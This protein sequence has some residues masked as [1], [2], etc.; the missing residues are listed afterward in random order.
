MTELKKLDIYL[1]IEGENYR[2]GQLVEDKNYFFKYDEDFLN[3]GLDISPFH[4]PLNK[5]IY[6]FDST[7]LE[8]LP[9][10]FY[11]S[12]PDGWGRLLIDR[13]LVSKK[14]D[15]T[16]ISAL[17]RLSLSN[18]NSWGAFSY[19]PNSNIEHL[20]FNDLNLSKIY[21]EAIKIYDDEEDSLNETIFELGSSSGGARPK[22]YVDY[23]I[24]NDKIFNQSNEHTQPWIIK[25]ATSAE[26]KD[27][28][29][30]EMIYSRVAVTAG[31][32]MMPCKLFE[33]KKGRFHFGTQRF[34]R[35]DKGRIH[36]ISAAGLL[37]DNFRLSALDYGHLLNAAFTLE[38]NYNAY[39]KV[40]R[41]MLFN[42]FMCNRDD[43]SKNF[44]FRMNR[45]G[46]WTFAPAYDLTYSIP[47]HGH[48]SIS[49][50]GE[51]I[52]P[53]LSDLAKLANTF[54]IEHA[55]Q[56]ID[57]VETSSQ[58]FLNLASEY[59]VAK[60]TTKQ[61]KSQMNFIRKNFYS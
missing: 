49:I 32:E 53:K 23:D 21:K 3:R 38:K 12:L 43:H 8:G 7:F 10:V 48:H 1:S 34:D 35:T 18:K 46:Q 22:I 14:V 39:E 28:A 6:S 41:L 60:S 26:I 54:K 2:V 29:K 16:K 33:D 25:F 40:F 4:L 20:P 55:K 31:I 17:S 27:S 61:I 42:I 37:H 36:C 19:I 24:K 56:I 47:L 51:S 45:K 59:D 13:Y 30:I 9:G 50:N 11:D 52:S 57:E 15:L 58:S 44:A 5:K